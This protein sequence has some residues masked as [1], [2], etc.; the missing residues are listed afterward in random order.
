ML[1]ESNG[2][3]YTPGLLI[4]AFL[5]LVVL[6]LLSGIGVALS[7]SP[8]SD[9]LPIDVS[10]ADLS[11]LPDTPELSSAAMALQAHRARD[12]AKT[13]ALKTLLSDSMWV[14]ITVSGRSHEYA[15]ILE[16]RT[17]RAR[18]ADFRMYSEV[19]GESSLPLVASNRKG[20]L[21]I[22]IPPGARSSGY[23]IG[24]V[25]TIGV[26]RP[27]ALLWTSEGFLESERR[28][29]RTGGFLLG[30]FLGLAFLGFM[31]GVLNRDWS[32][33]LFAG[34]L[35]TSLRVTFINEGWDLYWLGFDLETE[36][37]L[38]ILRF[39]LAAHP[40]LT[41]SL[42]LTLLR[43]EIESVSSERLLRYAI[44]FYT[45]IAI[46]APFL[47]HGQLLGLVWGSSALG[48]LLILYTL[49]SVAYKTRSPVSYWYAASWGI[50]FLG[51]FLQVGYASGLLSAIP[52]YLTVQS[53]AVA[54][55]LLT[56]VA[57]A[58][59]LRVE[60]SAR[61]EAQRERLDVLE[62]LH[63][64]YNGMPI[65]LFKIDNKGR[66]F[67]CNPAFRAMFGLSMQDETSLLPNIDD[68][69]TPMCVQLLRGSPGGLLDDV[70]LTVPAS[71]LFEQRWFSARVRLRGDF[72]EGSIQDITIRK[73]AEE[74][75][76][77]LV[78]HDPLTGLLNRRGLDQALAE[79]MKSVREGVPCAV[80]Y[81]AMDRFKLINDLYGHG[82]GDMLLQ[83]ASLRL[84]QAVRS[85]DC[86]ARLADA[87][88]VVFVDCPDF[89]VMGLSERLRESIGDGAFD[90]DAKRLDITV[91]VGVVS[92]DSNMTTLETM[93][94][95]GRACAEA[96]S[97]GRNCVVRLDDRDARLRS[98]L[99]ELRVV[100]DL[101]SKI[102][103]DRYFLEFQPIVALCSPNNSLNYEVLLRM[104]DENGG[105]IPPGRFIGAAERN[106]LMSDIDRWVLSSTLEWLDQHPSHR[107]RLN[108]ATINISGASLNDSR[109]VDDAFAMISEHPL[110]MPKLCFEIT[111]SVALNDIGST[112][113]FIDRVRMYGSKLALDDFGAGY[114]SFNYLKEIPADFIK[115]DGSFVKDISVNPANYAITRTIVELT[116]ELG[117]RSIAEWAETAD[118][119]ASLIDLGVDYGQG[120]GLAR[121]MDKRIVTDALSCADLVKDKEVLRLLGSSERAAI[122]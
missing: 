10:L 6:V 42:F 30:S 32:F 71:S 85:R 63:Q 77:H 39:T 64:N 101:K 115:I 118:T 88:V 36:T 48:I 19:D 116:H 15:Q 107:D 82:T 83:Q 28:F 97:R 61:I 55:A 90:L 117:M 76:R 43:T 94:S 50:T 65:G 53:T 92:V 41:T 9:R 91:S 24:R 27:S 17:L 37:L 120:F 114:T 80:A 2:N 51:V 60:R 79:A 73:L 14:C 49:V 44:A 70:E 40:L 89:A 109:F 38:M 4:K 11:I 67:L 46:S 59:R 112:R 96:K 84:V 3:V 66:I 103:A 86:I 75:L 7:A 29:E 87:F 81:V 22:T 111:E 52:P 105:V 5:V 33:F 110:A 31:I 106:G 13:S 95:A 74:K 72:I 119:V 62:A 102:L 54:S 34:W 122:L 21:A 35:V 16:L 20:G 1:R 99:E 25:H 47:P 98:H 58:E 26:S 12:S 45:I 23:I 78:D 108:F 68:I 93:T 57:L 121:P 104:R 8:N 100:A 69:L 56:A 113:R 18:L